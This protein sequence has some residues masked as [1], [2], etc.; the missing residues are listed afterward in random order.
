[1]VLVNRSTRTSSVFLAVISIV[2]AN[3][4]QAGQSYYVDSENG[5]DA[6][7]GT[8]A[9]EAWASLAKVSA[10]TYQPGDRLLFRSGAEWTGRLVPNGNGTAEQAIVID[11]YGE[12]DL[13]AI[14]GQGKWESAV[15]L[16]NIEYWEVR[17]LEITNTGPTRK[18]SR[19]GLIVRAL[20]MGD[21]RGIHLK[22]LAIHD[23]NG[24]LVKREGG[25]SAILIHNGGRDVPTRFIDLLIEDCHLYRCERNGINFRG[26]TRRSRWHPSLNVVIRNNLL[27]Q[28]PGDG[29]V[30]IGCDGALVEYN[31][32]RDCPDILPF[33]DAAAGI[34]PWSSD[35]TM[36]QF[37]EVSDHNAKWDGQGFD[38]DYNCIGT[39]IQYN[40]SHNNAGGF[41]L[42]CNKGDTLGNEINIGTRD[43]V[44]RYNLSIKDGIREY[45]TKRKGWF[46]PAFHISGP[47][48]NTDIHNNVIIIPEKRLAEID[49][50]VVH[51]HNWG[52]SWPVNTRIE[53]NIFISPDSRGF[54]S[55]GD[56][57]TVYSQNSYIGKF[58]SLPDDP[59]GNH[60]ASTVLVAGEWGEGFET[61]KAFLQTKQLPPLDDSV[62]VPPL[63]SEL[64]D[65]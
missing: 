25:G 29:I 22:G 63:V 5:S 33:G 42:I 19:R 13:P 61:M 56:K 57:Y 28:I 32:M 31:V 62:Q 2:C 64:L 40:Y 11:R 54:E 9:D 50:T 24:S 39:V 26:N 44:V 3:L 21:C 6:N 18:A 15:L 7:S 46:S 53:K 65:N 43:T 58:E 41:L 55:G 51:F 48:E 8:A 47:C 23:V 17:N 45:P 27:E 36:I 60:D 52:G 16:E 38:A 49:S 34:W 37:N 10:M 4:L 59:K 14:H 1:M 20:N 12:G 35:N 30:P